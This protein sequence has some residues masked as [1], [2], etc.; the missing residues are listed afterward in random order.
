MERRHHF[1]APCTTVWSP[2]LSKDILLLES[3]QRYLKRRVLGYPNL[4][5][6]ERLILLGLEFL[7]MRRLHAD[8]K[9]VGEK[10]PLSSPVHEVRNSGADAMFWRLFESFLGA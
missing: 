9:S 6:P 5:Y 1:V 3:V 2:H 10:K 8:L 4:N 7:G